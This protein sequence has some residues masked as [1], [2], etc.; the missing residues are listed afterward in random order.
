MEV[1]LEVQLKEL[2]SSVEIGFNPCFNGSCFGRLKGI[3]GRN[4]AE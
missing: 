1:A 4:G 2:T 3:D